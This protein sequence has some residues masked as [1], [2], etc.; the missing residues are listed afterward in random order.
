MIRISQLVSSVPASKTMAVSGKAGERY[1]RGAAAERLRVVLT[2]TLVVLRGTSP[3][4]QAAAAALGGAREGLVRV[5]V[6]YLS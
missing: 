1:L 6:A 5:L 3:G 2:V 4:L